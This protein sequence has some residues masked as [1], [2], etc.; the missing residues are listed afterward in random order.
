[1]TTI[2]YRDGVLAADRRVT[3]SGTIIGHKT[4]IAKVGGVLCGATGSNTL[5]CEFIAWVQEGC[6]ADRPPVLY[7]ESSNKN[8]DDAADITGF[9][10]ARNRPNRLISFR[11]SGVQ[12]LD[13]P[14]FAFGSGQDYC[15]GAFAM[16][17]NAKQAV[18]SA[19]LFDVYSGSGIDV[20]SF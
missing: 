14:Y 2:A 11:D 6:P 8:P 17:A 4:K 16:G 7:R 15:R 9:L 5:A 19:L 3:G 12:W 20:L 13:G 10:I 1:M 18:E